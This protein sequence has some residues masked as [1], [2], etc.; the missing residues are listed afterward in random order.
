MAQRIKADQRPARGSG[1][2]RSRVKHP[3]GNQPLFASV[4]DQTK[5]AFPFC[6]LLPQDRAPLLI[7]R[8]VGVTDLDPSPMMMGS[9]LSLRLPA[10]K[11]SWLILPA[12]PIAWQ[13][14]TAA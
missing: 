8:V 6:V 4:S 3:A 7:Q 13:S 12:T 14:P 1:L 2:K 10:P 5:M 9:M 11:R